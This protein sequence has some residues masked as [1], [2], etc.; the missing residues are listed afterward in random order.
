[1]ARDLV[2]GVFERVIRARDRLPQ[3]GGFRPWLWTI[4]L[5][6]GRNAKRQ[7]ATGPRQVSLNAPRGE[8]EPA[9]SDRLPDTA[10]SPRLSIEME[11]RSRELIDAVNRLERKHRDVILLKYFQD[12]PCS[13]VSQVLGISEG[14]VWSRT[15]RAL[16]RL[17]ATLGDE[18]SRTG[19]GSP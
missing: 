1:M 3:D 2:Q 4:A 17:R 16:S 9:L 11:E 8:G 6:L 15:H 12:L 18:Q 13:E 10:P 14:T 5:N 7:G 19:G